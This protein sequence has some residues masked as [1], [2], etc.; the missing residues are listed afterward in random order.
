[1]SSRYQAVHEIQKAFLGNVKGSLDILFSLI[2][3]GHYQAATDVLQKVKDPMTVFEGYLQDVL[4]KTSAQDDY[5]KL[6]RDE[7]RLK[8]EAAAA[9]PAE[10]EKK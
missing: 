8:A 9:T 7:E 10:E 2:E 3:G 5:Y 4:T 1:M 6:Q